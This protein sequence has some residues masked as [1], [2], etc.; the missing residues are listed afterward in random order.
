[1]QL[2]CQCC[3]ELS[4]LTETVAYLGDLSENPELIF[5][6]HMILMF[7]KSIYENRQNRFEM[8]TVKTRIKEPPFFG[9][10]LAR[11]L[12]YGHL[13]G[14]FAQTLGRGRVYVTKLWSEITSGSSTVW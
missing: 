8:N 13:T 2:W 9:V 6:N 1:M 4:T 11:F 7:K 14:H 3:L 10:R 5:I 12:N